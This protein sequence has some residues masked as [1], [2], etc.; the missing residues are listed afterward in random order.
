MEVLSHRCKGIT[1]MDGGAKCAFLSIWARLCLGE[2][3]KWQGRSKGKIGSLFTFK[4]G[5]QQPAKGQEC[6]LSGFPRVSPVTNSSGSW[7]SGCISQSAPLS[8]SQGAL[9]QPPPRPMSRQLPGMGGGGLSAVQAAPPSHSQLPPST[10][11]PVH[12]SPIPGKNILI[13]KNI[14]KTLPPEVMLARNSLSS[15][16]VMS[17]RVEPATYLLKNIITFIAFLPGWFPPL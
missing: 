2:R 3:L 1:M 9:P 6:R 13:W 11:P 8:C 14:S 15:F 4:A 10:R 5:M 12:D 17:A 7:I 16:E